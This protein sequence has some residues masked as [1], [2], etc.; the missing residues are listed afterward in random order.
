MIDHI[1]TSLFTNRE[2]FIHCLRAWVGSLFAGPAI[3]LVAYG[4]IQREWVLS[5][6]SIE[7]FF[8]IAAVVL[9]ISFVLSI[10]NFALLLLIGRNI[11][12]TTGNTVNFKLSLIIFSTLLALLLFLL[13]GL[14]FYDSQPT[15]LTVEYFIIAV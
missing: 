6:V 10:P 5:S 7:E 2:I 12:K 9:L 15:I 4:L 11:N 13:L 3:A 1:S 14:I 8:Y